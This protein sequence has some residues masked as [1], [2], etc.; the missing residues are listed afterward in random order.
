MDEIT[1]ARTGRRTAWH[2]PEFSI[3]EVQ[4]DAAGDEIPPG[5]ILPGAIPPA[6]IPP[7]VASDIP[8]GISR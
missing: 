3:A 4:T 1:R 7:H 8:T 5:V 2:A 6:P